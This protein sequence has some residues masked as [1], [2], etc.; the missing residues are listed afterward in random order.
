MYA[1]ICLGCVDYS[2][3]VATAIKKYLEKNK[4]KNFY[5]SFL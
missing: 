2:Y 1:F 3:F 5:L 4:N